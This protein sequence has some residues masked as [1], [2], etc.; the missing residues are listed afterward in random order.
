MPVRSRRRIRFTTLHPFAVFLL[1][2]CF[3]LLFGC[4]GPSDVEEEFVF[5]EEDVARY[6]ELAREAETD[7][8]GLRTGTGALRTDGEVPEGGRPYLEGLSGGTGAALPISGD[9]AVLDLSLLPT[10]RA[11]RA[12]GTTMQGNIYRV[13]NEF[14]NVR[15]KAVTTAAAVARLERGELLEVA[16]FVN[17]GWARVKTVVGGTEGF[18]A[19]QYIA[20]MTSD[21]KLPEEK[22][23]FAG[24]YYVNFTF[25]NVRAAPDQKSEKL[26]ELPSQ[27]LV[28]PTGIQGAWA[29]VP[30][31]GGEGYVSMNY[32]SPFQPRFLV[33]QER[34]E[35]PVLHYRLGQTDVLEAIVQHVARLRQE[36]YTVWTFRDFHDFLLRQEQQDVRIP[37]KTVLLALSGLTPDTVRELSDAL[38]PSTTRATL[39]L[40]AR[41]L[42]LSGITEKMV[43]TLQANG[44][45]LQSMG[46]TGDD[47][48]ALTNAQVELELRQSRQ[49]LEGFTR[50]RVVAIA[51]PQGGVNDR[52]QE[53]AMEA[54]YLL[55]MTSTPDRAFTRDQL[56]RL[57]SYLIF[58]SMGAEE[59][60]TMVRGT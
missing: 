20:R 23:K 44:F 30:F 4:R 54:G 8:R 15:A 51:Y 14:L 18:V 7:V 56:L 27:A 52:V 9:V 17:A 41:H 43:L 29:R 3:G 1:V 21:Q 35:L 53:L 16:E 13:T 22:K 57:P 28:K 26:G 58:P 37:A 24:M 34:Y 59:V 5:T 31:E 6:R 55:G 40:E 32:L 39:F 33:R 38:T 12:G 60:L 48:R 50:K 42:G 10:Y 46:H 49:L 11:I 45:D 36:G 47:L 19:Q 2:A 25:V